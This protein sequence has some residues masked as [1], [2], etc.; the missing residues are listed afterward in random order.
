MKRVLAP[1]LDKAIDAKCAGARSKL[2]ARTLTSI[3]S[4]P[5]VAFFLTIPT[6]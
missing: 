4:L 2:S 6:V 1:Q 5:W 3:T